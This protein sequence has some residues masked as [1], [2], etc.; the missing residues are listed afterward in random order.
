MRDERAWAAPDCLLGRLERGTGA[1]F[2]AALE[3]PAAAR[4]L[5]IDCLLRDPRWDRQLDDTGAYYTHLMVRL[6]IDAAPLVEHLKQGEGDDRPTWLALDVLCGLT[7][8]GDEAAA[9]AM[10]D[11]VAWGG[12]WG[13]AVE[14]L[15][16]RALPL[17]PI[18]EQRDE[19]ARTAGRCLPWLDLERPPFDA[20]PEQSEV[21]RARREEQR[22]TP[23]RP[24]PDYGELTAEQ[25]LN[26]SF[27]GHRALLPRM[28]EVLTG[29][30]LPRLVAALDEGP[31]SRRALAVAGLGATGD[32]AALPIL[33]DWL[34]ATQ[35]S[36]EGLFPVGAA[37]W[38][39][40]E[41]DCDQARRLAREWAA[42]EAWHLHRVGMMIL[43][44][45]AVASDGP[46]LREL[47]RRGLDEHHYYSVADAA[48]GLVTAGVAGPV[49]ELAEAFERSVYGHC[50][51]DV[52]AASEQ[53]APGWLAARFA[54]EA[55]WDASF[56]VRQWAM[57]LVDGTDA[58]VRERLSELATDPLLDADDREQAVARL[59]G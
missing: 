2:F 31:Y 4:P 30:H 56:W 42:G 17:L 58:R 20:W 13:Q 25:I 59:R 3:A 53:L 21:M 43:E 18:V 54:T 35:P 29:E 39:L 49:P 10:V 32:P 55:L 33:R 12:H 57:P 11:Y 47:I 48:R 16:E 15:G 41:L 34:L 36:D 37:A 9:A 51:A 24:R 7:R 44:Q 27:A 26:G 5:V 8:L 40:L 45:A 22:P 6:G 23:P 38:A 1:G 50:R 14:A 52:A 19:Q 46:L 28:R